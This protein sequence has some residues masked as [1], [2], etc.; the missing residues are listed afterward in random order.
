MRAGSHGHCDRGPLVGL[1]PIPC[2]QA[3][4]VNLDRAFRDGGLLYGEVV[5][6]RPSS[7]LGAAHQTFSYWVEV[8]VASAIIMG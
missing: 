3:Y 6:P 4:V 2:R 1:C 5:V 7:L 8:Y